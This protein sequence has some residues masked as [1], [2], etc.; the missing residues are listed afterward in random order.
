MFSTWDVW[1]NLCSLLTGT[2]TPLKQN[3]IISPCTLQIQFFCRTK[4]VTAYFK[5]PHFIFSKLQICEILITTARFGDW[6]N[7]VQIRVHIQPPD[8][9]VEQKAE[10]L[11]GTMSL[12]TKQLDDKSHFN[13]VS[14][15]PDGQQGTNGRS[16][17]PWHICLAQHLGQWTTQCQFLFNDSLVFRS[18]VK[19]EKPWLK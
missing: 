16:S 9:T 2:S 10:D 6:K 4:L 11:D 3:Y 5:D 19:T 7:R 13:I 15:F 17:F 8:S 1:F 14:E 18:T 12:V